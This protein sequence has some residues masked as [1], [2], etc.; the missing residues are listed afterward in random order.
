MEFGSCKWV[1][2]V[3]TET[4]PGYARV[5]LPAYDNIVTPWLQIVKQRA[6]GDDENWPLAINEQ[7]QCLVDEYLTEG[8]I[9]GATSNA[10]DVPDSGAANTKWRKYFSDGTYLE[11]DKSTKI[12]TANIAGEANITAQGNVQ[13]TTQ[14]DIVAQGN[15]INATAVIA[16]KITAP[17]ITLTGNVVVTGTLTAAGI[18]TSAGLSVSGGTG[19][20]FNGDIN[21][22]GNINLGG[23]VTASAVKAGTIDLATHEH[24]GVQPGTGVSGVPVP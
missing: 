23:N 14:G 9:L 21:G 10:E 4:E 7:V 19:A 15:N 24:G 2:G 1:T 11:Y 6:M 16:A 20:Q 5:Q 8:I 22:T 12:F 3:V 17:D 18:T 13:L